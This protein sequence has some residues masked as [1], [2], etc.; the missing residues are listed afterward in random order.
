MTMTAA[1]QNIEVCAKYPDRCFMTIG[2]HPYHARE[3]YSTPSGLEDLVALAESLSADNNSC[4]VAFGEIGLDYHYLDKADKE[5]QK[6]AFQDQLEIATKF[7]LPLFLHVRD[8]YDDFITII[9]PFLPRLPLKGIVHS[10]AGTRDEMIGLVKLGF[11]ISVNGVSFS[12]SEQLEMV[13]AIPLNRLQLETDAPWCEIP[14]KGPVLEYLRN[15]PPLPPARKPKDFLVGEMVKGRNESCII[16]R[17]A[18]IVAGIK[19]ISLEEVADA[20]WRNSNRMFKLGETVMD[21]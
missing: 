9:K 19:A 12:T 18:R 4:L 20:A 7:K 13:R 16:E 15:S 17:V 11:D 14:T 5:V 21:A 2:I 8:S 1:H 10:F 6:K 3:L